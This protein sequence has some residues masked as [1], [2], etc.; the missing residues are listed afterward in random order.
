MPQNYMTQPVCE[1]GSACGIRQSYPFCHYSNLTVIAVLD[2]G[3]PLPFGCLVCMICSCKEHGLSE[4]P[5]TDEN[6]R[7]SQ[8]CS[9]KALPELLR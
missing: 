4:V 9:G 6:I 1:P 8:K 7:I 2:N 5:F 3:H